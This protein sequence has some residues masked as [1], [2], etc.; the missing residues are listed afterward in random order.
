MKNNHPFRI[1]REPPLRCTHAHTHTHQLFL[2]HMTIPFRNVARPLVRV[3]P[4]ARSLGR[5]LL[6]V[7]LPPSAPICPTQQLLIRGIYKVSAPLSLSLSRCGGHAERHYITAVFSPTPSITNIRLNADLMW[8]QHGLTLP[9][10]MSHND[11]TTHSQYIIT[12]S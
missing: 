6:S 11:D 9:L 5:C 4:V 7:L 10:L 8:H 12:A 1:S 3:R 2:T